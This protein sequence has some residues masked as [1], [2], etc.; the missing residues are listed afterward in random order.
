MG[1]RLGAARFEAAGVD[2]HRP[3]EA[4][5][6]PGDHRHLRLRR[7]RENVGHG[8]EV[9]AVL[10]KRFAV[11]GK[12]EHRGVEVGA[13]LQAVDRLGEVVV[14]VEDRVVVGV[15]DF[16]AP[17]VGEL[18]GL[19]GRGEAL[20]R[21]RVALEIGRPVAAELVED[22]QGVAGDGLERGVEPVGQDLVMALAALAEARVAG[23]RQGCRARGRRHGRRPCRCRSSARRSRR[24]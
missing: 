7:G 22:D 18:G 1:E 15:D 19:A 9:D 24:A 14:G 23:I 4:V 8:V 10:A 13:R 6:E 16:L 20:E 2:A 3:R 17:A 12:V 5:G 11:V 21:L